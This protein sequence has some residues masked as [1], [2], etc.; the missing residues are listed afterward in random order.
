MGYIQ[1]EGRNEGTLFPVVLDDFV[2]SAAP[3]VSRNLQLPAV[4]DARDAPVR[5]RPPLRKI[6]KPNLS[7]NLI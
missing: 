5:D 6:P 4:S 2:P 1:G 7:Q 3:K